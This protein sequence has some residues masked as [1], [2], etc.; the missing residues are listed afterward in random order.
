MDDSSIVLD[1]SMVDDNPS[2]Q[3][4]AAEEPLQ[5]DAPNPDLPASIGE[6]ETLPVPEGMPYPYTLSPLCSLKIKPFLI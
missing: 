5:Q 2:G 4:L 1:D 6:S 3:P